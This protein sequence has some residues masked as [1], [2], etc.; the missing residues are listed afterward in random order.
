MEPK[1]KKSIKLWSVR[2]KLSGQAIQLSDIKNDYRFILKSVHICTG[3]SARWW[4]YHEKPK[5]LPSRNLFSLSFS[6]PVTSNSATPWTA[7]CQ[8]SLSP[9]VCLSSCSLHWWCRPAISSSDTLLSFC[10]WSFPASGTFPM[11]RLLAS[12]DQNTGVSASASV[13]LVNIQGW[14]P[15]RLTGLISLPFKGLSGVFSS[16]TVWRHQ[17]FSILPSLRSSSHNCTWPLGRPEPWLYE[18]LLAK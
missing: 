1:K 13:L 11:S 18:P 5:S 8:A 17:F 7:A 3:H 10:A 4:G 16:T 6:L 9:R 12:D 15:L 14:S 2:D